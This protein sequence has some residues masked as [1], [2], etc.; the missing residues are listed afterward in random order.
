VRGHGGDG[1]R[2]SGRSKKATALMSAKR[3]KNNAK[4]AT[5]TA[6]SFFTDGDRV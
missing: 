6:T 5:V 4:N 1:P 2:E 3:N